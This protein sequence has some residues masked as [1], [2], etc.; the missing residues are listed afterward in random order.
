M[1]S[2]KF[3]AYILQYGSIIFNNEYENEL[4][5]KFNKTLI[6]KLTYKELVLLESDHS[7]QTFLASN[8]YFVTH[9]LFSSLLL[10]NF[11]FTTIDSNL[12]INNDSNLNF[13]IFLINQYLLDKNLNVVFTLFQ[14]GIILTR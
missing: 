7:L 4:F 3:I 1:K 13:I 9:E 5:D 11:H 8:P 14:T 12:S 6:Y 2:S 10:L